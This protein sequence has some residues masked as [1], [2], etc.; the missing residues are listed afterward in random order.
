MIKPQSRPHPQYYK[1]SD[2]LV[3]RMP[4]ESWSEEV[5]DGINKALKSARG[6]AEETYGDSQHSEIVEIDINVGS[7]WRSLSNFTGNYV[8]ADTGTGGFSSS[9]RYMK[10]YDGSVEFQGSF[11]GPVAPGFPARW[12]SPHS[13]V[14]LA[15]SVRPV[16]DVVY[17]ILGYQNPAGF[18]A[19]PAYA[20]I[21]KT[22]GVITVSGADGTGLVAGSSAPALF[23]LNFRYMSADP[24][25]YN[26]P[27]FPV[28][29]YVKCKDP[30]VGL[31]PIACVEQNQK[32]VRPGPM[33][34]S[35]D[36]QFSVKNGEGVVTVSN[37]AYSGFNNRITVW[38]LV[39]YR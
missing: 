28:S 35:A 38:F 13:V 19:T 14:T 7:P 1:T 24:R 33:L 8:G 29:F 16:F 37:L 10:H 22:T 17:P 39:I 4:K 5:V 21:N 23:Y 2:D 18:Q 15:P 12:W 6:I 20:I 30:P 3:G 26:V 32:V 11:S 27:G 31:I 9:C 34:A 36:W 25:P